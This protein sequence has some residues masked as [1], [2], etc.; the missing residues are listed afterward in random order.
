MRITI[1]AA[2]MIATSH[3]RHLHL[4]AIILG[5]I[6]V[7]SSALCSTCD[8][9]VSENPSERRNFRINRP[10]KRFESTLA[11]GGIRPVCLDNCPRSCGRPSASHPSLGPNQVGARRPR[12]AGISLV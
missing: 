4:P 1:I 5:V 3:G 12:S 2:A 7:A 10:C 9:A 8:L 11:R 6:V